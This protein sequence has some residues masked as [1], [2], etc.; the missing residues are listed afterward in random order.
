M[1]IADLKLLNENKNENREN[2]RDINSNNTDDSSPLT[3]RRINRYIYANVFDEDLDD[4][5]EWTDI[6]RY[7][8]QK[9]LWKLKYVV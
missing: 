8:F 3:P 6:K 7:R 9:C 1:E 2:D 5:N 4:S